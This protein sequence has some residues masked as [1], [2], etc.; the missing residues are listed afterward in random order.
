M[1][2]FSIRKNSIL[3]ACF[4]TIHVVLCQTYTLEILTKDDKSGNQSK[5]FSDSVQAMKFIQDYV[6]ETILS[7]FIDLECGCTNISTQKKQCNI[8][9][10][11]KHETFLIYLPDTSANLNSAG[12]KEKPISVKNLS[13]NIYQQLRKITEDGYA[14]GQVKILSVEKQ[15]DRLMCK[16]TIRN[17]PRVVTDSF[18]N[19]GSVKIRPYVF[20]RISGIMPGDFFSFSAFLKLNQ[21][22][23]QSGF[24]QA[25]REPMLR[26]S[27]GRMKIYAFPDP[28]PSSRFDAIMGLQPDPLTSK[29]VLTGNVSVFL[30]NSLMHHAEDLSL[31]WRRIK[32]QTQEFNGSFKCPYIF[33]TIFGIEGKFSLYRQDSTFLDVASEGALH[34]YIGGLNFVRLYTTRRTTNGLSAVFLGAT[35]G[36]SKS[37]T[38]GIGVSFEN[39]DYSPNPRKGWIIKCNI[40]SGK[41][42]LTQR[43]PVFSVPEN[44]VSVISTFYFESKGSIQRFFRIG[45]QSCIMSGVRWAGAS[46]TRPLLPSELFRSGGL[47]TWRGF[48]ENSFLSSVYA[49]GTLEYRFLFSALSHFVVFTDSGW[50]ERLLSAS[51]QQH[52]AFGYGAGLQLET[53]GGVLKLAYALGHLSGQQPDIRTGKIHVGFV[54]LF[55]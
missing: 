12:F 23:S 15:E 35:Q 27:S 30:K 28:L 50:Y 14:F 55:R 39:T 48:D 18:V 10:G 42:I 22:L 47:Q 19:K 11:K 51:Y 4:L 29:T 5:I 24:M 25:V 26:Y 1:N 52:F 44:S 53:K 40:G 38:G 33:R 54:S 31:E 2:W 7:S 6:N 20:H 8:V 3:T 43:N 36:D 17:G 34:I 9:K 41:R 32:V 21:R 45:K 49:V 46:S 13:V 16:A 37:T